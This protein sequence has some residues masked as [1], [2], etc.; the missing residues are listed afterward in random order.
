M[1]ELLG[2]FLDFHLSS[3]VG[4]C[5]LSLG[6]LPFDSITNHLDLGDVLLFLPLV[7]KPLAGPWW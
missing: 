5:V 6:L 3:F 7:S 1:P 2:A 4:V